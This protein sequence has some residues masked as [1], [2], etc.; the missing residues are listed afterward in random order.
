LKISRKKQKTDPDVDSK[1]KRKK[2]TLRL[3]LSIQYHTNKAIL[4]NLH[5]AEDSFSSSQV[6]QDFSIVDLKTYTADNIKDLKVD[7]MRIMAI[8]KEATTVYESAIKVCNE[9]KLSSIEEFLFIYFDIEFIKNNS[10]VEMLNKIVLFLCQGTEE[11]LGLK[12]NKEKNLHRRKFKRWNN[13]LMIKFAK[14]YGWISPELLSKIE[15]KSTVSSNYRAS[16]KIEDDE[17]LIINTSYL[18]KRITEITD[19]VVKDPNFF[20][21]RRTGSLEEII[22]RNNSAGKRCTKLIKQLE[23]IKGDLDGKTAVDNHLLKMADADATRK[24][25]AKEKKMQTGNAANVQSEGTKKSNTG[26]PPNP[27]SVSSNQTTMETHYIKVKKSKDLCINESKEEHVSMSNEEL[28]LTFQDL[29]VDSDQLSIQSLLTS[30]Q[31]KKSLFG[32]GLLLSEE[33]LK[34]NPIFLTRLIQCLK[35]IGTTKGIVTKEARDHL[36]ELIRS[37]ECQFM[38]FKFTPFIRNTAELQNFI[39]PNGYCYYQSLFLIFSAYIFDLKNSTEDNTEVSISESRLRFVRDYK[40]CKYSPLESVKVS[41]ITTTGE[42]LG[43]SN[44]RINLR[45][46]FTHIYEFIIKNQDTISDIKKYNIN[47]NANYDQNEALNNLIECLR[48][49]IETL[50]PDRKVLSDNDLPKV[51]WPRND[52]MILLSVIIY[53]MVWPDIFEM[54]KRSFSVD[55]YTEYNLSETNSLFNDF[56][57]TNDIF[58]KEFCAQSCSVL[59]FSTSSENKYCETESFISLHSFS[60]LMNKLMDPYRRLVYTGKNHFTMLPNSNE[61]NVSL[62]RSELLLLTDKITEKIINALKPINE[63]DIFNPSSPPKSLE[64]HLLDLKNHKRKVLEKIASSKK[65]QLATPV[66]PLLES[67]TQT[68][69]L[70]TGQ[71]TT[72]NQFISSDMEDQNSSLR[73]LI[74]QRFE[75][76]V[77][78]VENANQ[79]TDIWDTVQE[80]LEL[81]LFGSP[82]SVQ[83]RPVEALALM[84][85][86]NTK[87]TFTST[88]N[89]LSYVINIFSEKHL[90]TCCKLFAFDFYY[91]NRILATS[92]DRL[93]ENGIENIFPIQLIQLRIKLALFIIIPIYHNVHFALILLITSKTN[94]KAVWLDSKQK[95]ISREFKMSSMRKMILFVNSKL[96]NAAINVALW[97]FHIDGDFNTASLIQQG[98][99]LNCGPFVCSYM[100]YI[101][102][103]EDITGLVQLFQANAY[104]TL[105]VNVNPTTILQKRKVLTVMLHDRARFLLRK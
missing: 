3:N 75:Q 26:P 39:N 16:K 67:S 55:V 62:E 59:N 94:P 32:T 13:I 63:T 70:Y 101:A 105:F 44:H 30:W 64:R 83:I 86:D 19:S 29:F 100:M 74:D 99:T 84:A 80:E 66:L 65:L 40:Y 34:D 5:I 58:Q 6:L 78:I 97:E 27:S 79:E 95:S 68:P 9:R 71:L 2:E 92:E 90:E 61:T 73:N 38:Y 52:S 25:K 21:P 7:F 17:D 103:Q 57:I 10:L 33:K 54:E 8:H 87:M 98:A 4:E 1:K 104:H 88:I 20:P 42:K 47:N 48:G 18:F 96:E 36:N 89:L 56:P 85:Q 77:I 35:S 28:W 46:F 49:M 50:N 43:L 12:S 24:F 45:R 53:K 41:S 82:S 60:A 15:K 37:D 72:L 93:K 91:T 51:Y 22:I 102:F 76:I 11:A 81:K 69:N 14:H 23:N 31:V